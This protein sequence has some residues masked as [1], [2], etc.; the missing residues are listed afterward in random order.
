MIRR[1]GFDKP[2]F[3][4][5]VLGFGENNQ[6]VYD[7]QDLFE[8]GQQ[9]VW[10]DPSD[11]STLFQDAAGTIPVTASGD[12][13][14]MIK[15]KSGNGNHAKQTMSS[16]R[17]VYV[18][19]P[20]RLL[21]DGVDDELIITIPIGGWEGTMVLASMNGTA[22]Y[23][24]KLLAGK[25]NL[26]GL[27]FSTKQIVGVLLINANLTGWEKSSMEA[28]FVEKGAVASFGAVSDFT[29]FWRGHTE[30][31]NFPMIDTSNSATLYGAW[32]DCSNMVNVPLLETRNC[33]SFNST[34]YRCG[35][36][37]SMPLLD[38]SQGEDFKF[39]WGS[40]TSLTNF[41]ANAFDNIKGT[42][43]LNA[44]TST[45][46]TQVSIDNI[47]TSIASSPVISTGI[48]RFNQSGG[49]AP[50]ALGNAA[51]A[52]LRSAGWVVNVTGG[53]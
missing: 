4:F 43:F 9:G 8:N 25:Y 30:I 17:L 3:G 11:I 42:D 37:V 31:V 34:W 41:P 46:L 53:Y 1:F 5:K 23:D 49:S 32:Y 20:D 24:V 18:K 50:S 16:K 13:V 29:N 38:Y 39:A 47:L 12:P 26:G 22:S 7:P 19:L 27:F 35:K 33:K 52:T 14:G 40:C 45:N 10:Y 44:F 21:L 6:P 2:S 28:I 51:I 48:R 15:D 36:L